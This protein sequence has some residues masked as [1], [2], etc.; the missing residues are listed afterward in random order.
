M[1]KQYNSTHNDLQSIHKTKHKIKD[2]VTRTPIKTGGQLRCS[3]NG[4]SSLS[5]SDTRCVTLYTKPMI[6]HEIGKGP[7]YAYDRWNIS[8]VICDSDI[9]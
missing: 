4:S 9:L 7:G 6:S 1:A 3:E 8:M 5:N 2:R